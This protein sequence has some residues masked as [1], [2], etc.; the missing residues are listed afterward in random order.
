MMR[1]MA[2]S[3]YSAL[4]VE[5]KQAQ[6]EMRQR[7]MVE[8][9]REL[10]RYVAG[11]DVSFSP[12]KKTVLAVAL[13]Y[14]RQERRVIEVTRARRP[15]E[16][17]YIPG[18]LSFR[19]GPAV[20]EAIGRLKSPFG[21]ICCDGQGYAHP[22][23]CGL[24]CHVGITLDRPCIGVAKSRLVGT[25]TEPAPSAGASA[26]LLDG[27]ETIG[28]VL[29]TRDRVKPIFVSVGHRVDLAS[30]RDL[31]LGCVTR[32]RIPEPTRQADIEVARMKAEL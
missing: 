25:F 24:A 13:V 2:G 11:A 5:W 4:I 1:G 7:L 9:L 16:V 23:R 14:D 30:A 18:Y 27:G 22:R 10:P 15:V 29:R 12:D 20:L 32:Y 21:V 31:V 26:D 19:E 6:M 3:P 17:P 8:P 28:L